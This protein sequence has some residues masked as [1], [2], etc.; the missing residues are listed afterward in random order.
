MVNCTKKK[1]KNQGK[2]M[3]III[4]FNKPS[5]WKKVVKIIINLFVVLNILLDI[6]HNFLI[7]R[8]TVF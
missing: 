3:K 4:Y 8:M 6:F 7:F 2:K 5:F 1:V